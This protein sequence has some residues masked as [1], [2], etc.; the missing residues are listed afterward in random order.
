MIRTLAAQIKEYKMA[1]I[2]TPVFMIFE[3]IMETLIPVLMASIIDL[4]VEK[5]DMDHIA[6]TGVI[7]VIV[8]LASLAFGLLGAVY[9]SKASAGFAKN[10]RQAMFENIQTF[11]FSNIDRFS[12][13]SLVTRLTT[14]VTNLQNSFQMLLRMAMRAPFTLLFAMIMSFSI[15]ARLA[16]VYLGAIIFLGCIMGFLISRAHGFF[17]QVFE[18]YD[19]LNAGV[20]ENITAIREVKS[21]VREDSQIERFKKANLNIYKMFIGAEK[22]MIAIAPSMMLTVYSCIILISWFGAKMIV[23]D[24]L[25]TGQLMSLLTYCMNI[26]MNLMMLSMIAVMMTMSQA[27]AKRICE[28]LNEESDMKDPEDPVTVVPSGDISFENVSFRYFEHSEKPVLE[29]INLDIR[30]GE[31]IG[32]IGA[33]GSAKTSLVNLISRLYDVDSGCV[34]V[35]GVDVRNY[36]MSSLR[37]AVAVVLQKNVLFSGTVME[38]LRWG[39]ENADEAACRKACEMACAHEFI[40][41]LEKGYDSVVEQG[42]SNFSGGQRQRL[43]I[44]RALMSEPKVLILD[45]STS[46]VDTA[47]DAKIREAFKKSIPGVTKIIIAQRMSSVEFADRIIV[48]DDGRVNAVGTHEEL[49][50]NNEIYREVYMMQTGG[51]KDFDGVI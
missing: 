38:N 9:A 10:L 24:E 3:V 37:K 46:A 29:N 22:H 27:S 19:D 11:S 44:A 42:G 7:M 8:A 14:D 35:G 34:K 25:T 2:M 17:K 21:F 32:I 5:G 12:T 4:G 15:N 45:D 40:E 16:T 30:S 36:K 47:T 13:A 39:N 23:S 31:T 43:C 1:S 6:R 50:E 49:L 41:K 33:T 20:Q 51:S 26:L 28:V 48:M 18:K